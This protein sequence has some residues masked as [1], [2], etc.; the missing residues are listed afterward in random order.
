VL[1]STITP[2]TTKGLAADIL[3][4]ESGLIPG[5]DFALAH[6]QKE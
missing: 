4:E 1:E 3:E 6:A 2:G 5:E